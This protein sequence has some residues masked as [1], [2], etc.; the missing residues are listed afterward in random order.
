VGQRFTTATQQTNTGFF[1][2]LELNDLIKVGSDPLVLLKKSIP[3]YAKTNE[4][5]NTET[6]QVLR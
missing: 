4:K 5:P 2:Q 1:V 3:G 6:T